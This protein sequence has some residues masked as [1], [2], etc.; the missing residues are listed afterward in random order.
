MAPG[1]VGRVGTCTWHSHRALGDVDAVMTSVEAADGGGLRNEEVLIGDANVVRERRDQARANSRARAAVQAELE[2]LVPLAGKE[3][4]SADVLQKE[5]E[6]VA[7]RRGIVP[8][9][10]AKLASD[11]RT[12]ELY[13]EEQHVKVDAYPTEVQVV[14]FAVWMSMRRQR[15][16][17]AQRPEAGAKLTGLGKRNIRNTIKELFTHAWPRR[18][19]LY[20]V[21]EKRERAAYEYELSLY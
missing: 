11:E 6:A 18:F 12:W 16:C 1:E 2:K 21:L 13:V 10:A 14:E 9:Y 8:K 4:I 19:E 5:R 20:A 15:A 17:L 7:E 3:A